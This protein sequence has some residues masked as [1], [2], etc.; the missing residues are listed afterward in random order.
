M[1]RRRAIAVALL[2]ATLGLGAIGCS[3]SDGE[4]GVT[5]IN[6]DN[7]GPD[8]AQLQARVAALE[9]EVRQLQ[10]RLELLD[11]NSTTTTTTSPLR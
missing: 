8:I 11:P 4:S 7:I 5:T 6:L 3:S 2:T 1:I 9:A 10:K